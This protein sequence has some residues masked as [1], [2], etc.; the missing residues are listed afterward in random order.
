MAAASTI[1]CSTHSMEGKLIAHY[2]VLRKIGGGGMG[3]A[4]SVEVGLARDEVVDVVGELE[5][6]G[7]LVVFWWRM[8]EG[9]VGRGEGGNVGR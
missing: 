5:E 7:G 9:V 4:Q 2:Q 3:V 8:G 6:G 1:C